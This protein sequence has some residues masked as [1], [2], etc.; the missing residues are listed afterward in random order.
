MINHRMRENSSLRAKK[1]LPVQE[2]R[3]LQLATPLPAQE[4]KNA[5]LAAPSTAWEPQ[6]SR[7][8]TPSSPSSPQQPLKED[9][10]DFILE[11]P[12][13]EQSDEPSNLHMAELITTLPTKVCPVVEVHPVEELC[14][15]DEIF[16]LA[17]ISLTAMY[18]A[19]LRH[20]FQNFPK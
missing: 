5:Q 17:K 1:L 16:P 7:P 6:D 13:G 11:I 3:T 8:T 2:P 18:R 4:S 15:I 14:P 19:R 20:R 9:I 10:S 12:S